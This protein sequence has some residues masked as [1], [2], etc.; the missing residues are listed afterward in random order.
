MA[1]RSRFSKSRSKSRPSKM[2]R[3]WT[4]DDLLAY[5]I[6]VVHEDLETFFGVMNLPPPNIENDP[7][8]AQRIAFKTDYFIS[9]MLS[10]INNPML[11]DNRASSTATFASDLLDFNLLG[12]AAVEPERYTLLWPNLSY[13][14][15]QGRPPQPDICVVDSTR[16]VLLVARVDRHSHGSDPEPRLISDA[17]AAFHNSNIMRVK[18]LGID[19]ITSKIMPGIVMDGTMPTF[20]KVPITPEL[21]TAVESGKK[22]DQETIVHV[23]RPE[24]RRPEEGML[25]AMKPLDNRS[26][27]LSCYEAF[28]QFL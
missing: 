5:N 19:P 3:K 10:D 13:L 11:P 1:R 21:V 14:E 24:V 12:Y 4:Q 20:Y 8:A 15:T 9:L 27:I 26:I 18:R 22:P 28:K 16:T 25:A 17:I 23:Y 6:K 7:L 2:G